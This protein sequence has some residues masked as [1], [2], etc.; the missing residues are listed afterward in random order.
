MLSVT[1]SLS[2]S[3]SRKKLESLSAA[4]SSWS[5]LI[6][7]VSLAAKSERTSMTAVLFA[8]SYVRVPEYVWGVPSESTC[9]DPVTVRE[10]VA[11]AAKVTLRVVGIVIR[12]SP[13]AVIS[14]ALPCSAMSTV[15]IACAEVPSLN[16]VPDA[17]E[18]VGKASGTN[19]IVGASFTPRV[20]V[21]GS[22]ELVV[23]PGRA[24]VI[25]S[26]VIVS[27]TSSA[28]P[29]L[30]STHAT[31]SES[32]ETTRAVALSGPASSLVASISA[33]PSTAR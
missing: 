14:G 26:V 11:P 7:M 8:F 28:V 33:L 22:R 2:I 4:A 20:P 27:V 19:R 6:A 5:P 9:P 30:T 16:D 21:S 15:A 18:M 1:P 13:V 10:T 23:G 25:P 12:I 17:E 31:P 29:S 3:S 32:V 24:D